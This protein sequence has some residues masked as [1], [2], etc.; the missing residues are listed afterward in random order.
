MSAPTNVASNP[1][2]RG[3]L[4]ATVLTGLGGLGPA[5]RMPASGAA[6]EEPGLPDWVVKARQQIPATRES[7][8]FQTGGIG[9]SPAPVIERVSELLRVQNRGP[10]T[11]SPLNH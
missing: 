8:Y 11:A 10:A 1:G 7:R 3:F 5:G 6:V 2:R 4:R 9:A